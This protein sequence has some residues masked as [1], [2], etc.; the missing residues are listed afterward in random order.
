MIWND[1]IKNL[2]EGKKITLKEVAKK[3]GVTEAT[4]QRYENSNGIKQIPYQTIEMYAEIFGVSPS[5]IMGWDEPL[6]AGNS[7]HDRMTAYAE[8]LLHRLDDSDLKNITRT[9]E[10]WL[11]DDKYKK[12]VKKEIS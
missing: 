5:Y 1:R 7:E 2:R 10:G 9:M 6:R 4:A 3:L 11:E 12:G 8:S